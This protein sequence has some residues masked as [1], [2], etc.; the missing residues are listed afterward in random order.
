VGL[1]CSGVAEQRDRF[2]GVHVV[3][4]GELAGSR[5]LDRRDGVDGEVSEPL[6]TRQLG[7]LDASGASSFGAGVVAHV[8]R[9]AVG[10]S[11]G[12]LRD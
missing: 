7:V 4:A 8:G 2:A 11:L 10:S 12:A 9:A 6:Q 5:G 1:A 3:P